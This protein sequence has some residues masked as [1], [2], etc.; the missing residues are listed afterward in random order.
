MLTMAAADNI[1]NT[2]ATILLFNKVDLPQSEVQVNDDLKVH[3][4]HQISCTSGSGVRD[5]EA[6]LEGYVYSALSPKQ[7][8]IGN[9]DT[10]NS[11]LSDRLSDR[12]C[13]ITRQRHRYHIEQSVDHLGRFLGR[14]EDEREDDCEDLSLD[15]KAEEL[16]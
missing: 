12:L 15:I 6:A 10:M 3:D 9:K 7:V 1:S 5:F 16:R 2:S 8:N 14:L 4:V 11:P 13:G